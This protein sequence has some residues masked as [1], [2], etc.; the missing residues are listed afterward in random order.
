MTIAGI[1]VGQIENVAL[2]GDHVI[3]GFY[4]DNGIALGADTRA[5]IKLT[6]ILGSRYLELSPAGEGPSMIGRSRCP[7]PTFP[8]ICSGLWPAQ[9][10]P[11]DR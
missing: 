11:S 8:T 6:T 4:L 3:V 9:P 5:A 1:K 2:A 7:T 10:A